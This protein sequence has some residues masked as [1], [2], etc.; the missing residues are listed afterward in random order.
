MYLVLDDLKRECRSEEKDKERDK[1]PL[2]LREEPIACRKIPPG[3]EPGA[4]FPKAKQE[5]ELQ[6]S[7]DRS[8]S[9]YVIRTRLSQSEKLMRD[10][11]H[12][13]VR[14]YQPSTDE[15]KPPSKL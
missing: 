2:H 15:R 1:W 10:H 12:A 6:G 11:W 5:T 3:A 4:C 14:G 13:M 7:S 8:L 9:I